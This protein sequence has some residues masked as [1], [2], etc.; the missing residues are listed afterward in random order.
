MKV[1]RN[2]KRTP[3]TKE[4]PPLELKYI[5][6]LQSTKSLSK[7]RRM[8]ACQIYIKVMGEIR[9]RKM[10]K[11][12]NLSKRHTPHVMNDRLGPSAPMLDERIT[13]HE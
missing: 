6:I 4:A 9:K 5:C 11:A 13:R 7:T 10:A 12:Q 2:A 3:K 8:M 1:K